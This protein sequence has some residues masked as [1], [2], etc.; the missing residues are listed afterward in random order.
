MR[1]AWYE[2]TGPA[3]EVLRVGEL[4]DP[5]P[6]LGEVLVRMAFS[7][8]NPADVKVRGG[9]GWPLEDAARIVPHSDGSGI[10]ERVGAGVDPAR[11]GQRVWL[12]EAFWPSPLGTAAELT[13]IPAERAVP[14]PEGVGLE[15][16]ACLGIPA[17]TAHRCLFADG[18]I[19]GRAILVTGGAGAVG[20]AAIQLAKRAG[21]MVIATVSG[22]EK[23]SVARAAGADHVIDY[24]CEEVAA[25]V[26]AITGG[27]GIDRIVEVEFGGNLPVGGAVL[28]TG[29]AIA[30]YAS[31]AVPEPSVPFYPLMYKDA[32]LAFVSVY[33]MP[34]EA[35]A[36]AV[37]GIAEALKG[38]ALRPTIAERLPLDRIAEAHERIERPHRPGRIL[39]EFAPGA[40]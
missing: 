36:V 9:P 12:Y 10:I 32:R 16:G 27:A 21:A 17:M 2:R 25:R 39:L 11:I 1:A 18:P 34:A 14:L 6:A 28:K 38:G 8:V 7:A 13:A 15:V 37:A 20:E 35:K 4:A 33:D 5:T 26:L 3:R 30:A 19:A 31:A 40:A 23:A 29:G 22:P 24:R